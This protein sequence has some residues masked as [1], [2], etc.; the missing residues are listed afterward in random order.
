MTH[1]AGV[2]MN[3]HT[4]SGVLDW[5]HTTARFTTGP[6]HELIRAEQPSDPSVA[7][8][9]YPSVAWWWNQLRWATG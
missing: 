2:L 7:P 9:P 5:C 6:G 4:L 8:L 1:A 3:P